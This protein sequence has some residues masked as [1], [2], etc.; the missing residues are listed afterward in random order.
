MAVERA[1][2]ALSERDADAYAETLAEAFPDAGVEYARPRLFGVL[3]WF[4]LLLGPV[5]AWLFV[6][7]LTPDDK[8]GTWSLHCTGRAIL[9]TA[10]SWLFGSLLAIVALFRRERHSIAVPALVLNLIP[11]LGLVAACVVIV[12]RSG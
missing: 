2:S 6:F 8:C 3:A 11:L 10:A 12:Q 4:A 7:G 5:L 9:F 1:E